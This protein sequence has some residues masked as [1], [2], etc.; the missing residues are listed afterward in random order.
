MIPPP[1]RDAV[2]ELAEN[3]WSLGLAMVDGVTGACSVCPDT[4]I[5]WWRDDRERRPTYWPIHQRC[6]PKLV[7]IWRE[8]IAEGSTGGLAGAPLAGAYAR[9]AAARAAAAQVSVAAVARLGV[10]SVDLGSPYFRPGMPEGS[11]VTAVAASAI[12]WITGTHCGAD[13]A[14]AEALVRR[15]ETL[16]A[17][18]RPGPGIAPSV[19]GCVV[20]P[21]GA[22]GYRWGAAPVPGSSPLWEPIDPIVYAASCRGCGA[23]RWPGC[24]MGVGSSRCLECLR[25]LEPTRPWWPMDP[26]EPAVI[27]RRARKR[28]TTFD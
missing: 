6:L 7:Q 18:D 9:R 25:A 1:P 5:T 20:G 17:A 8:M 3:Q 16:A 21:D 11:P 12:G 14:A 2:G 28:A 10:R 24:W 26:P 22:V 15:W 19:G 4:T 27:R 13:V 23:P